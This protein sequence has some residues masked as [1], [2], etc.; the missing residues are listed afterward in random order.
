MSAK[1]YRFDIANGR[2][3]A[4]YE[5][6]DGV[7]RR[8]SLDANETASVDDKLQVTIIETQLT[9]REVKLY[10]PSGAN[11]LYTLVRE[12]YTDLNGKALPNDDLNQD[13]FDDD[14]KDHDGFKDDRLSGSDGNDDLQGAGGD[15]SLH[16]GAGDDRLDGGL[17]DD[18]LQSGAGRDS[19]DG[20][21]GRDTLELRGNRA[22]YA[23]SRT[24]SGVLLRS[25]TDGDDSVQNVERIEFADRALALDTD[26]AAGKAFRLYQAA[27]DRKPDLAGLGYWISRL[28]QDDNL[29]LA[30]AGFVN[31][32]EFTNKYG[33]DAS[34]DTLVT[35][36]YRNVLHREPE[37]AG[38]DWWVKELGEGRTTLNKALADFS[39]SAEN[40]ANLAGLMGLGVEF[41]PWMG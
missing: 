36:L 14:D 22:E 25:S 32:Q 33:T 16:G 17:G 34:I 27:F 11:G 23:L 21:A 6:D 35:Q 3:V 2:L 10:A 7:W 4:L 8:K 41:T 15:D 31:S 1:T 38:K 24:A 40:V 20:G 37:Q 13:G 19:V 30:A 29:G 9:H 18:R 39:E 28:D 5:L 12:T 26:G